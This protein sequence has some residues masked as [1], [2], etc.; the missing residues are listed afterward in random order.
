[1]EHLTYSF[2]S[3][4]YRVILVHNH[5]QVNYWALLILI[6]MLHKCQSPSLFGFEK[7]RFSVT[8]F[9]CK[10]LCAHR[11]FSTARCLALMLYPHF[12]TLICFCD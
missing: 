11:Y 9:R 6:L 12:S 2:N 1:M 4:R 8:G 7:I 10:I 5:L 3:L